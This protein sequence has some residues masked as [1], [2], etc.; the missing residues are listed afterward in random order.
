M[1]IQD[2]KDELRAVKKEINDLKASLQF[3]QAQ[4]DDDQKKANVLETKIALHSE[5]LNMINDHADNVESQLE[6]IENQIRRNNIKILGIEEDENVE[7]T[8]G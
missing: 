5:N 2:V 1:L 6:Y 3:K 7:K 4:V 8:L